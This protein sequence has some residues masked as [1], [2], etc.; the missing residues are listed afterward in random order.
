MIPPLSDFVVKTYIFLSIYI[1]PPTVLAP[2][3]DASAFKGDS[4]KLTC[5]V[6]GF[7][8][9]T[10]KWMKDWRP[11]SDCTRTKMINTEPE[12]FS[13]EITQLIET[14][15]GLYACTVENIAGKVTVT[16]RLN[17]EIGNVS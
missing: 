7:P 13:L 6:D 10:V 8:S 3:M 15:E 4:V 16:G 9:P 1:E 5:K 11:L 2:V 17:V 12:A 14:D